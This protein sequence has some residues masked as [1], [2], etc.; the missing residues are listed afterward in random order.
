MRRGTEEGGGPAL[1]GEGAPSRVSGGP[2]WHRERRNAGP[3]RASKLTDLSAASPRSG[4]L[5]LSGCRWPGWPRRKAAVTDG[6]LARPALRGEGGAG[7]PETSAFDAALRSGLSKVRVR[8][9]QEACFESAFRSPLPELQ[10]QQVWTGA[11]PC[12]CSKPAA[13]LP[14]PHVIRQVVRG[15]RLQIHCLRKRPGSGGLVAERFLFD[16][17][18]E[19][20]NLL[21]PPLPLPCR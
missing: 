20:R 9:T 3:R 17:P 8:I 19:R 5:G 14:A 11:L 4:A 15:P 6:R 2:Q 10:L 21:L 7:R 16:L 1:R 18:N 12:V 13:L